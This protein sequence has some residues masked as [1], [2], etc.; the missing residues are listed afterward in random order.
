[1]GFAR[2]AVMANLFGAGAAQDAFVTALTIPNV[3]RRLVAEG[4][5]M[6]AFVPILA[7]E[8]ERDGLPAMRRF[9]S[10]L[11]GVLLPLLLLLAATGILIPEVL[12]K[13]FAPGFDP[14]R[15]GIAFGLTKIM[16]PFIIFVSLLAVASGALNTQGVFAAPAAAPILLNASIIGCSIAAHKYLKVPIEAAAWGV[17]LGGAVQ[18]LLQLPFLWRAGLL[19]RPRWEPRNPAVVTLGKRML[20]A[21]FGVAVYQFNIIVIRQFASYLPEGQMSCYFWATRLEEFALGVFAVSISIAALPTLSEHA[22][23]GDRE[24]LYATFRRAIRATNFITIPAMVGLYIMAAPIVGVLF[25]HGRF[26]SSS[27]ALTAE[28]VQIMAFALVP[29]GT[30]RVLVPAYYAVGDTKTPVWAACASLATMTSL[31][32]LL[33]KSFQIK[34]LTVAT[35]AAAA[36]QLIVLLSLLKTRFERALAQARAE[37]GEPD[38]SSGANDGAES[39]QGKEMGLLKHALL[40]AVAIAPPGLAGAYAVSRIAWF[41]VSKITGLAILVVLVFGVAG[42]YFLIGRMFRLP[43][44]ELVLGAVFRRLRRR[45]G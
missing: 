33:S 40:C 24:A 14:E 30:V 2:D 27:A 26:S 4:S 25:K 28:L 43:E 6:I 39:A 36:A 45:R 9:T 10:A 5:L 17:L 13:A 12:V 1:M 15:A 38:P 32:F 41:E 16:M 8:K 3:L 20:P 35:I 23:R 37:A 22:A 31:G 19:V 42:A 44:V 18:L 34:G 21:L 11:L 29:I 7:A